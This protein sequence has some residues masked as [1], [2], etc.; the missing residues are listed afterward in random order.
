M[1]EADLGPQSADTIKLNFRFR[2][3]QERQTGGDG[4]SSGR[5]EVRARLDKCDCEQ[6]GAQQNKTGNSQGEKTIGGEFFTHGAPHTVREIPIVMRVKL[7]WVRNPST[8]LN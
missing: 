4:G 6:A 8:Q 1:R 7:M 2:S 3:G 5:G